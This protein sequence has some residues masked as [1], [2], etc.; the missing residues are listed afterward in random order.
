M[1]LKFGI[2]S[3]TTAVHIH[4]YPLIRVSSRKAVCL[5]QA[6]NRRILLDD[7]HT[8]QHTSLW[9]NQIPTENG[10]EAFFSTGPGESVICLQE[11][12]NLQKANRGQTVLPVRTQASY[13]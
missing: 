12:W 4:R 3:A 10:G 8:R 7:Q 1:R 13:I 6:G 2:D 9:R 5:R 11:G